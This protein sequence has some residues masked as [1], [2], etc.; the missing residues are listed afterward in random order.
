MMLQMPDKDRGNVSGGS[1]SMPQTLSARALK[2]LGGSLAALSALGHDR[3]TVKQALFFL[4]VAYRHAMGQSVTSTDIVT[5]FESSGAL[6][7]SIRKSFNVFLAPTRRD[8]DALNWMF[9]EEDEDDR[10]NKYLKLT[11]TGQDVAAA[12]IEALRG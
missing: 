6:G 12:L 1:H 5:E 8:P 2:D 11:P 9:Q 10:R 4:T 7:G 3:M